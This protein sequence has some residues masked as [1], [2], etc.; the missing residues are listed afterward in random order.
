MASKKDSV[1]KRHAA[2]VARAWRDEAFRKGLLKR[3]H[4]TLKAAGMPVPKGMKIRFHESSDSQV[5]I[6]I[7]AK[8]GTGVKA[9]RPAA[10]ANLTCA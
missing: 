2:I 6:V 5:H 9:R 8:P 1:A 10:T 3:P 7:P 4:A